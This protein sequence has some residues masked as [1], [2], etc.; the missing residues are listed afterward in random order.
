MEIGEFF[1]LLPATKFVKFGR[2]LIVVVVVEVVVIDAA[3]VV[4]VVL[5]HEGGFVHR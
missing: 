4:I 2:A 5:L 3:A 1:A